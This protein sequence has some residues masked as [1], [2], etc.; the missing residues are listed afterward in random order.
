MFIYSQ[1]FY[2]N[3]CEF[4]CFIICFNIIGFITS[5]IICFRKKLD[6]PTMFYFYFTFLNIK[7]VVDL[8]NFGKSTFTFYI[9]IWQMNHIIYAYTRYSDQSKLFLMLM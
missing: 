2:Q 6:Y 5:F 3:K 9:F 7:V 4:I 8:P 1:P